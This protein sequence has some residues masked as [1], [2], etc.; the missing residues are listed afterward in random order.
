MARSSVP[1]LDCTLQPGGVLDE[2][3][4]RGSRNCRVHSRPLGFSESKSTKCSEYPGYRLERPGHPDRVDV[5]REAAVRVTDATVPPA[6]RAPA[7]GVDP[8][9]AHEILHD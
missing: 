8:W 3:G 4:E 7:S 2:V 5:H 6:H 1:V 9:R